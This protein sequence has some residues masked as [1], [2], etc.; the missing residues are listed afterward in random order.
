MTARGKNT[1]G[2]APNIRK[3]IGRVPFPSEFFSI[4]LVGGR[5]RC[6]FRKTMGVGKSAAQYVFNLAVETAQLVAGPSAQRLE[7]SGIYA[8]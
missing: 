8:Q 6:L 7:N 3:E 1:T 5:I 4:R 2:R